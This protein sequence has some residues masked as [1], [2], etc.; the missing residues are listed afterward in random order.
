MKRTDE[1]KFTMMRGVQTVLSNHATDVAPVQALAD[2]KAAFDGILIEIAN[3]DQLSQ[4]G[5]SG[6]TQ[7]K[8]EAKDVLIN[9][10][11]V[12]AGAVKA[13]ATTQGDNA[14]F[15][16]VDYTK[17]DL[18]QAGD[19]V[20]PSSAQAIHDAASGV[21]A[22]LTDYG[23][24]AADLADFQQR[25]DDYTALIGAPRTAIA[26]QKAQNERLAGLFDRGDSLLKGTMDNLMIRF[27]TQK[28]VFFSEYT[29]ARQIVDAGIRHTTLKG[30]VTDAVTGNP[31]YNVKVTIVELNKSVNTGVD[32]VYGIQEFKGGVYTIKAEMPGYQTTTIDTVEIPR[33]AGVEL[34]FQLAKL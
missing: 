13:Y 26:E 19:T 18:R 2:A 9:T 12:I 21:V 3:A 11:L 16:L 6:E 29:T 25:I 31:L 8:A 28:P 23:V 14:L 32:G 24:T 33:G 7:E 30:K 10:A 34:S 4:G 17:T 5:S 15:E 27:Q 1:N 22:N 20:L